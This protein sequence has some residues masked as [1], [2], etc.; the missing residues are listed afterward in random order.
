[1]RRV[2]PREPGGDVRVRARGDRLAE[3]L[4]VQ[5][6]VHQGQVEGH[7]KRLNNPHGHG[8]EPHHLIR[9]DAAHPEVVEPARLANQRLRAVARRLLEGPP[10]PLE[11][12]QQLLELG[13]VQRQ[14]SPR[15]DRLDQVGDRTEV[16]GGRHDARE[17][18]G[19]A[20]GMCALHGPP[21][22]LRRLDLGRHGVG[23]HV[24]HAAQRG[25]GRI[26]Q[27]DTGAV[28]AQR[29]PHT[30]RVEVVRGRDRPVGVN[31]HPVGP[32]VLRGGARPAP[33]D[34]L[35]RLPARHRAGFR[36]AAGHRTDSDR[37]R[38]RREDRST[39]GRP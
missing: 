8:R 14:P 39:R 33:H 31:R 30:L 21:T 19:P 32:G 2:L 20:A 35:H 28:T 36:G 16:A 26:D 22:G 4:A 12:R 15:P 9:R 7:R 17:L 5:R 6:P 37:R 34:E 29:H 23:E 10:V 18:P 13:L 27:L 3:P 24:D 1:M 11:P 25:N 38:G